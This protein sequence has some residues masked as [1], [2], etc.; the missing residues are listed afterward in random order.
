MIGRKGARG[1][2]LALVTL[3]LLGAAG[4]VA[5]EKGWIGGREEAPVEVSP[6][7]AA[8]AEEKLVRLRDDGRA[9]HLSGVELSSLLRYRSPQWVTNMVAEPTV[10]LSGDTLRLFGTVAT[11]QLPSH[12][13]LDAARA[14]LP[15]SSRIEVAGQ[16][17]SLP[18][19]RIA[20]H[21][22]EVEIA[23]LPVPRRYYPLILERVGREDE[24][25]LLDN[26]L[27]VELPAGVRSAR[28]ERGVLILTP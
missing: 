1:A 10:L 18:S 13:E 15:D 3:L 8:I 22:S 11:D 21:L 20:L 5:W 25:G 23:G 2:A 6:E 17:R 27:A 9:A 26:A 16:V 14:F 28:I 24:A 19:G 7:S 12:P 4:Y